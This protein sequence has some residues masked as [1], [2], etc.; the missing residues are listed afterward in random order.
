[1]KRAMLRSGSGRL[2]KTMNDPLLRSIGH[3]EKIMILTLIVYVFL[4]GGR[5][6]PL[7]HGKFSMNYLSKMKKC[8]RSLK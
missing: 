3:S 7:K 8:R 1:M 4:P 6:L 2:N 5:N